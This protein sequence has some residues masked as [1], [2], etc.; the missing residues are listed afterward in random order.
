MTNF[1]QHVLVLHEALNANARADEAD[2]LV[3]V[4]NVSD[5]MRIL[6][7][8][9]SVLATDLDLQAT[10]A[11]IRERNPAF[12]FNLVESLNGE[13]RLIH[14]VPALLD[15]AKLPYT[16]ANSDAIY[17]SSQK[18]LAKQW[19]RL[20][21]VPTPGHFSPGDKLVDDRATWIVKSVWE[22]ASFGMD[23]GCVVTG[24]AA[25]QV[26]MDKCI[27]QHGGEWFAEEFVDGREF[28]VSVVEHDGQAEILPIAEMTFTDYPRGKPKI[29]GYAAKWDEAAP[30]YHA[31]QRCFPQLPATELEAL[32]G[33][34]YAC[35]RIFG[36][37]GYARV[38]IRMDGAGVPWVLEV[39]ANPCLSPD[40]G[41]AAAATA[42]GMTYTQLIERVARAAMK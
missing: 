42:A 7:W 14:L 25:A 20:N 19:M 4:E 31:T 15:S 11:E 8:P 2:A 3:Q 10:L 22:H 24:M 28:N 6:G 13:G 12:V 18:L 9:V 37:T 16:G 23:D 40:A 38:D 41:F 30:E 27:A 21:D 33:V 32:R 5:A 1:S 29:V 17:L 26:R 36:L 39:N 35:W 34:V